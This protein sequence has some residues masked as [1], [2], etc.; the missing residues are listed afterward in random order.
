MSQYTTYADRMVLSTDSAFF[1][2]AVIDGGGFVLRRP[3]PEPTPFPNVDHPCHSI[4]AAGI[5]VQSWKPITVRVK[6]QPRGLTTGPGSSTTR[7]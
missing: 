6:R 4:A 2:L 3:D 5:S 1:A 7:S